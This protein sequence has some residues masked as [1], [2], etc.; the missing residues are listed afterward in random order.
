MLLVALGPAA[1]AAN[2]DPPPTSGPAATP[3]STALAAG[4][5]PGAGSAAA[6]GAPESV[7]ARDVAIL[8]VE[9]GPSWLRVTAHNRRPRSSFGPSATWNG[10]GRP[11][12]RWRLVSREGDTLAAGDITAH[13]ALE[14]PPD[15]SKGTPG[16]HT[17]PDTF[18]FAVKV[19][20][21]APGEAIEIAAATGSPV[22]RWP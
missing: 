15:P 16:T 14:L 21:P 8:T 17:T 4:D 9:Q 10:T 19:P 6:A 18:A 13:G 20:Q 22:V 12:H 5:N 11:T 1:C 2:G 3:A 7:D